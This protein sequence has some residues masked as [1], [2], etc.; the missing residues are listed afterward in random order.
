M[1]TLAERI[2]EMGAS[3]LSAGVDLSDERAAIRALV[4]AGY[5]Q[6]DVVVL[7]D[8]AMSRARTF[9]RREARVRA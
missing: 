8:D 2:D 9:K 1:T 7:V 6:G 5:R 3:L 4:D